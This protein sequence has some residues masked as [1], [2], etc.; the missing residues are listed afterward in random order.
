M[1]SY[2]F[3][4]KQFSIRIFLILN[5]VS[6]YFLYKHKVFKDFLWENIKN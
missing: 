2:D 3:K 6:A 4:Q 5:Q 1:K